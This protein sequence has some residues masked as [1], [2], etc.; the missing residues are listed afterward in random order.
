MAKSN[1]A[2]FATELGL[3]VTLL[4]EQLKAAGIAKE[5]ESD[6]ISEK[7][8]AKLLE[9]LRQAHGAEKPAKKI[10][11]IRRETTEIKKADS[12]GRARTIQVEVRKRRVVAPT[13]AAEA[14]AQA[15]PAP[16][17][18]VAPPKKGKAAKVVN[19]KELATREEEARLQAELATRQAVEV[20]AKQ[21]RGK[22]KTTKK[23]VEPEPQP[24]AAVAIK[25]EEVAPVAAA[26]VV[27]LAEGTLHK[28]ASK[29]GDKIVKPGKKPKPEAKN[30]PW[31]EKGHK[32]R[33]PV[34]AGEKTGVW[35][36][37]V[38]APRHQARRRT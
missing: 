8:K 29:P 5:Q 22:R 31:D 9:H 3:P 15:A 18:T 6:P 21:E 11:L 33:T 1:V 38:R 24:V 36:T 16:V 27:N 7:D 13:A 30:S 26:P 2:Q 28:P 4:L 19:E 14:A 34:K 32:K 23:A 17:E 35:T 12:S 37:P 20:Q 10:T 25:V